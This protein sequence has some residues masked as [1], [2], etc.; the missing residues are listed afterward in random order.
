M[1]DQALPTPQ[2]EHNAWD[3][4]NMVVSKEISFDEALLEAH[5]IND[6]AKYIHGLNILAGER[7]L[8][9][10]DAVQRV[11]SGEAARAVKGEI[12]PFELPY[13]LKV[14]QDEASQDEL[15]RIADTIHE[16]GQE[17]RKHFED[18][19][20]LHSQKEFILAAERNAPKPANPWVSSAVIFGIGAAISI[21][22]VF[23][24]GSVPT[25]AGVFALSV[26]VAAMV[27][28][29]EFKRYQDFVRQG[30]EESRRRKEKM[31][32]YD[33]QISRIDKE[34]R[35]LRRRAQKSLKVISDA[36][37][38]TAKDLHEQYHSLFETPLTPED[39]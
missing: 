30:S 24:S 14:R 7:C 5:K 29:S 26:T 39:L 2:G 25:A 16:Y 33:E 9:D 23:A 34:L 32:V 6:I 13:E 21:V 15:D 18:R 11:R 36:Q 20:S 3:L 8:D 35:L 1:S 37:P 31:A 19:D 27:L 10:G 17:S 28:R 12:P 38:E 22:I 4:A